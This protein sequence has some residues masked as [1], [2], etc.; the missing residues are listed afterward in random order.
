[1]STTYGSEDGCFFIDCNK[2]IMNV[3]VSRAE[4]SFLVFGDTRCLKDDKNSP[5]GLLKKSITESI[6]GHLIR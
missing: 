6:D 5:S 2:N 3:A 1:M 4:D